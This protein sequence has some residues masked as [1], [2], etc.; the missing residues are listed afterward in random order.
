MSM[1]R[2]IKSLFIV[3]DKSTPKK[4]KGKV[5]QKDESGG[6]KIDIKLDQSTGEIS[7]SSLDKFLKVLANS[8]ESSNMEGY[9]YLEFKQALRSL[10]EI[11]EDEA[12]RYIT[13]FTLAKTMGA[14]KESLIKSAKFY[15]GILEQ[16]EN[17]FN[18][19]LKKQIDSKLHNRK[20]SL[21]NLKE[22]KGKKEEQIKKL[23]LEIKEINKKIGVNQKEMDAA[24]QNVVSVQKSFHAAYDLIVNQ[25]NEDVKKIETY[26]K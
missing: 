11:E 12:K 22:R 18:D 20:Q 15:L 14:K 5:I 23:Q 9:D 19:S 16:E 25:I 10:D 7:K 24:A 8:M 17:K 1:L 2:K 21:E 3:E 4:G 26:L 6:K 13:S